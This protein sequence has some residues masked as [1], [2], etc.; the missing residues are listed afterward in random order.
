MAYCCPKIVIHTHLILLKDVLLPSVRIC[1]T[2]FVNF[3][4][5]FDE[6]IAVGHGAEV[7]G[8]AVRHQQT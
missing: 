6:R 8:L 3:V 5:K 2:F 4:Q 1:Q 7:V